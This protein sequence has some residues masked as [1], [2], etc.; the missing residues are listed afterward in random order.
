MMSDPRGDRRRP[1]KRIFIST[2][3][4]SG[5]LQGSF[6]VKALHQQAITRGLELEIVALGGQR[7]E[8]AG[9]AR[10]IIRRRS[11]RWV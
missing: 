6:L 9:V 7:M 4:V 1:F 8:R 5:D 10:L 3:E 2:G 11:V